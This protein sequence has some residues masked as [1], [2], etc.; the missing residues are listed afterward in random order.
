MNKKA[1]TIP[2]YE[3]DDENGKKTPQVS[4]PSTQNNTQN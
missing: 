4:Q 1:I 2:H 3:S